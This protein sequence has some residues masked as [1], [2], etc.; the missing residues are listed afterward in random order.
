MNVII[1]WNNIKAANPAVLVILVNQQVC[2]IINEDASWI[3][4]R[5]GYVPKFSALE[6]KCTSGNPFISVS[7]PL[8]RINHFINQINLLHREVIVVYE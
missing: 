1:R 7:F 8:E 6:V 3:N 2:Q 4:E 5:S